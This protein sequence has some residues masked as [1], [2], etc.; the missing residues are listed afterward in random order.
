V[1]A[2]GYYH[3]SAGLR[4]GVLARHLRSRRV[5]DRRS[6]GG[7]KTRPTKTKV[8]ETSLQR[9]R[10]WVSGLSVSLRNGV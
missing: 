4:P 7:D 6:G 5:G 9:S 3:R 1:G 8:Q 10:N 2:S